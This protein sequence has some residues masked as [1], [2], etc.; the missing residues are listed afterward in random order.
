[1]P[2]VLVRPPLR[3]RTGA[4]AAAQRAELEQ[5]LLRVTIIGAVLVG[6][7][8][9]QIVGGTLAPAARQA[10]WPAFAFFALAVALALHVYASRRFRVA[11][12]LAG[13]ALDVAAITYFMAVAGEAG[14]T[15]F[16]LYPLVAIGHALRYG[17]GCLPVSVALSVVGVAVVV[18]TS[19]FWAA[20][21]W[22]ISGLVAAL[23]ALPYYVDAVSGRLDAALRRARGPRPAGRPAWTP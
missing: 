10:F 4:P 16:A 22:A 12:R 7:L 20:R 18:A 2:T 21:P 15:A 1:M 17:R 13:V 14:A 11:R 3:R 5:G 23:L 19:D 8:G 9:Y 6:F